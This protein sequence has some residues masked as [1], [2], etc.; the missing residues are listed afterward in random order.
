MAFGRKLQA[1]SHLP[2][3][4]FRALR[5]EGWMLAKSFDN[6]MSAIEKRVV[7]GIAAQIYAGN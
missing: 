2:Q 5:C 3:A 6:E 7:Y 4:D 1:V